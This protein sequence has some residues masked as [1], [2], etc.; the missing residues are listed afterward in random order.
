VTCIPT[1]KCVQH[2]AL[3]SVSTGLLVFALQVVAEVYAAQDVV[4]KPHILLSLVLYKIV[5]PAQVG[6]LSLRSCLTSLCPEV[7]LPCVPGHMSGFGNADIDSSFQ[8]CVCML[9]MC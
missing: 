8:C 9:N 3:D 7:K 4:V 2:G 1:F 5:D 6:I